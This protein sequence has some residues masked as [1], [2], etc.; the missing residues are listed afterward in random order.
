[1]KTVRSST[2][3]AEPGRIAIT[4]VHSLGKPSQ[5]KPSQA[6]P[7]RAIAADSAFRRSAISVRRG[8]PCDAVFLA[9]QRRRMSR[10][11]RWHRMELARI[12]SQQGSRWAMRCDAK[13][14]DAM[15]DELA[16]T[17]DYNLI[18]DFEQETVRRVDA[19]TA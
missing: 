7:S 15:R 6:K 14:C 11:G 17:K 3:S 19:D 10:G 9:A 2:G 12:A 4:C 1:L 5:A 18:A 16:R 8:I 13:R